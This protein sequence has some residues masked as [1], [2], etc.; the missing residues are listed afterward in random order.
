LDGVKK[1]LLEVAVDIVF[2][3]LDCGVPS[4]ELEANDEGGGGGGD[5]GRKN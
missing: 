3:L 2:V 1:P 4:I 5:L